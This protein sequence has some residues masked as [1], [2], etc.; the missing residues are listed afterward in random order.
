M[1]HIESMARRLEE[2][3][4]KDGNVLTEWEP[5]SVPDSVPFHVRR[6]LD[7]GRDEEKAWRALVRHLN[8]Q[9]KAEGDWLRFRSVDLEDVSDRDD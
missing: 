1:G 3:L 7:G 6:E 8:A 9:A 5:C 2:R 4:V